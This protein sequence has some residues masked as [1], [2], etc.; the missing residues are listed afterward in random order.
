MRHTYSYIFILCIKTNILI[1]IDKKNI[2]IEQTL[3][4]IPI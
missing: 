1:L 4:A 3:V 2:D